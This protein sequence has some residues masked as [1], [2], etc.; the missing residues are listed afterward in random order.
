MDPPQ[1]LFFVNGRKVVEKHV[2]P[3]MMLLP[4]LRKNLRLTGTK[5]GCGGGGCGACT[6]MVSRYNPST[7][8]I[9]HHPVNACLTPICSLHGAAVTTVEGIGS[10]TTRLHP[11][12]ERIAKCHGTQCGFCT[13]GMVMSMYTLLRNHPEPTLDQLTDALGGNLCRCTGYRPIIDACK[14]FCKA[15]GCCQSKENGVCCSDRGING[16]AEFQEGDE[17]GEW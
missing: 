11:V 15:S 4:Y 12:Q 5:Y 7:K 2:D 3:E 14:T 1:L 9:R 13:P 16:L 6:V 17:V 10:S 8:T